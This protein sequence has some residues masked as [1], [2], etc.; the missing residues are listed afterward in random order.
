[1]TGNAI[2]YTLDD[3]GGGSFAIDPGTGVVTVAGPVDREA[4]ATRN[5]TVRATS[6]DG[7]FST[8]TFTIAIDDVNEFPVSGITDTDPAANA[9]P[10][11]SPVGTHVGITAFASDPDSTGNAIVYS[12]DDNGGGSFAIDPGTGV[13]TVA[14]PVDREATPTVTITVRA[15]SADGSFS[16]ANFII[17]IG[18]VNEFPISPI[19]DVDTAANYVLENSPM[20]TVVH[21]TASATDADS[22]NNTV[23][24]SLD[25]DGGGRFAINASTGVVTVLGIV[26]REP[27]PTCSITIRATSQDG[28]FSTLVVTIAIGDANEF[29]I[30]AISDTN[31]AADAVDENSPIGTTVGITAFASDPDA[32][33]NSVTYSL[34]DDAGGQFAIH[35]T[36]GVVT[37]NGVIDSELGATRSI[38]IRAMSADGSSSTR[39]FTIAV[40]DTNDFPLSAVTD[41]DP[42]P[43]TVPE[44]A[45]LGAVVGITAFAS[46]PDTTDNTVTYSLDDNAGGRFAI[47][48]TTG[49]VTV[50]GALDRELSATLTIVVRANSSDGSFSTAS[51]VIAIGDVDEFDISPVTDTD[52]AANQ[53]VENSAV[54]TIVGITAFASDSDATNNAVTY[55][56]TDNDGGRFAIHATTGVVT[57]AGSIDREAG[58]TRTITVR[59]LSADG[60]SSTATFTIS[61]SDVNENPI[62]PITDVNPTVNFVMENS[63]V[64]TLVGITAHAT[65]PD[66]T[67]N[68]VTY[69]L[70]DSGGGRFA[71]DAVS[72]VVTVS[73]IVDREPGPT[74]DIVVRAT[75]QDGSF[76]TLKIVIAIGDVDEFDISPISDANPA[77]N[78]VLENSAIGTVVGLTAYA[79]DPDATNNTVTYSLTDNDGGRFA[80]NASTGVVTV[81]GSIDRE[82]GAT[83]TITVRALSADGSFSTRSFTIDV[84]DA[85]DNTISAVVDIDPATNYVLENSPNGTVVGIT[86]HATDAD[87]TNNSVTYSL[88]NNAGGQ[89]AIDSTTGIV[90]VAGAIDR[91][92][93]ATRAIAVR[94]ASSD[95]STSTATLTISIGD[96]NDNPISAITDV[97]PAANQ[98]AENSPSGTLVGLTARAVDPDSTNNSVTYSLLD[99]SLGAFAIDA[100][101]G[102]I[103]LIG[104]VDREATP[105]R[106]IEVRAASVDGTSSTATFVITILNVNEAPS[107]LINNGATV[108]ENG[109]VTISTTQL[110]AQDIDTTASG[111]VYTVTATPVFGQLRLNG[112]ALAVG[113]AFTQADIDAGRVVYAPNGSETPTDGFNF[114]LSDGGPTTITGHFHIIV[115]P[116]NDSPAAV[117]DFFLIQRNNTLVLTAPG[118]MANDLDA[119]GHALTLS[120]ITTT[121]NGTLAI[122]PS[123]EMVYQPGV[124]FTGYDQFTYRVTDGLATSDVAV[125][126]IRISSFG[127]LLRPDPPPTP[128]PTPPLDPGSPTPS[129]GPVP[130]RRVP[131]ILT[132]VD[133]SAFQAHEQV[134]LNDL[135][136]ILEFKRMQWAKGGKD[137]WTQ[138][139]ATR[140]GLSGVES[141]LKYE[142]ASFRRGDSIDQAAFFV[143]KLRPLKVEMAPEGPFVEYTAGTVFI[144]AVALTAGFIFWA[145][146]GG[147]LVASFLSQVP[148]WKYVDPLPIFDTMAGEIPK[149][150]EAEGEEGEFGS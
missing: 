26:D 131:A 15:T 55:S 58:A 4:G 3:N 63:A 100:N 88:L 141:R 21:V 48:S 62:S 47:N 99:D 124:N 80:I 138:F 89:F 51:F 42:A 148:A 132:G 113:G 147:F 103:R 105:T 66:A 6:A 130:R 146:K 8:A 111:L 75:S 37:V 120:L 98:V 126:T 10:E 149:D 61:V 31:S 52:A 129:A 29:P 36:T 81:A 33:T 86:A 73:G 64:G 70:D 34:T 121:T 44:D 116:V 145:V 79:S 122:L 5:I 49:V 20:G 16:T 54:G 94:A 110:Q 76:S 25:D 92:A 85:N 144:T 134:D 69:S 71:I 128:P 24:Y 106:T 11:N 112:V 117:S 95:G 28:S 30:S 140:R 27:G 38:T 107:S 114:R 19:T 101:S 18:D 104:A 118:V 109:T 22:T 108:P 2:V 123:G 13:V 17:S 135:Q 35:A 84:G 9:V 14:G 115:T 56:L 87:V 83:R 127:P 133:A 43:N 50:V 143:D 142:I 59:A 119:E 67:N 97:N 102:V 32:T 41:I 46:D 90:T 12:L 7:S 82:A 139:Y 60:S 125:V 78:Y 136:A 96:V 77:A 72:G 39:T 40:A 57:V 137:M 53:V 150:G 93:G 65:D 23:T 74:C 68:V 91:E 45:A 1:S